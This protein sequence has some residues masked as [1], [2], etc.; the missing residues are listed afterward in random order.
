MLNWVFGDEKEREETDKLKIKLATP[1]IK[2]RLIIGSL[3]SRLARFSRSPS[4]FEY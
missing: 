3:L 1:T 4:L 2:I